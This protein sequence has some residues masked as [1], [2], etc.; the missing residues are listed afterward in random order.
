MLSSWFQTK[1]HLS[2]DVLNFDT[3]EWEEWS[4]LHQI[5]Q[6]SVDDEVWWSW[7]WLFLRDVWCKC[8]N[9]SVVFII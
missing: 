2:H 7:V 1:L 3:L 6:F 5:E 9:S 4:V 8:K